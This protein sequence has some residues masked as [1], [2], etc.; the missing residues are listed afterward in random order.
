MKEMKFYLRN[1]VLAVL[2]IGILIGLGV[3]L[4]NGIVDVE[5]RK[6][7][8][9]RTTFDYHI[10]APDKAQVAAIEADA[11]VESV[12]PY[13]AYAKAFSKSENVMLLASDDMNDAGASLL[14][15]GTLIEGSFDKSGAMLD[16]T[17]ADALGVGVGDSIS[18]QLLGQRY[19]KTVAAI[20][21]PSTLAILEEGIVLVDMSV[22]AANAPA[23]YGGAFVV[24]KDRDA[25]ATLLTDYAGEGN[26]GLTYDQFVELK[27]GN[28][29]PNQTEEEFDA[30]CAAKYAAYRAEVLASAKKDGGQVVD[31]MDAYALLQ[32]KI[33]TT[34]K[35]LS[36]MKL[37]TMIAAFVVFAVACILFTVTNSENDR[38]RRDA[39]MRMDKMFLSYLISS[40][41]TAV[42]VA[43]VAVAVLGVVAAGTYFAAD[44]LGV[45]LALA[46]P[47]VVALVPILLATWVYVKKL[48]G[49]S[50]ADE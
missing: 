8:Y 47:V 9:T 7:T 24:A 27:C 31:K 48:Y 43:G 39:G 21:L 16:K 11:S 25:V 4:I 38:I 28:K 17:A 18:F 22:D 34:E 45:V 42:A 2:M 33:L 3:Y 29:L 26:V 50:V 10:A 41:I 23:A 12:F 6:S 32:E 35:K 46:L 40:V 14:T 37:L 15:D 36:N 30:S 13:Y 44:C 19:T 20:Y 5:L 1:I 49:N